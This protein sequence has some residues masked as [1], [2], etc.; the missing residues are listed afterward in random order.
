M[1]YLV[2]YWEFSVSRVGR[3]PVV[4]PKN[5]TI[6]LAGNNIEVKG[7]NGQLSMKVHPNM[8]IEINNDQLKVSRPN[9]SNMNKSLH[10]LTRSLIN[11]M[12]VG[13]SKGF[14]KKLEI[15]GVGYRAE[16]KSNRLV[17]QLGFSHQIVF[18]PPPEIKITVDGTN[19]ITVKGIDRYLVGE[20]AAKI[21]SF[22]P[23]DPY[24]GKGIRYVGEYVRQKAGKTA[25]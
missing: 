23:P 21:R 2:I 9:D 3:L 22:R 7:A 16:M 1:L 19:I 14:E 18:V 6:N 24:K 15:I 10:G 8:R 11:N 25:G 12:I 5:V 4:I 17:L 13:V 20:I